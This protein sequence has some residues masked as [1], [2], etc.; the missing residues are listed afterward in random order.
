MNVNRIE[1][2]F[3]YNEGD[4]SFK[5]FIINGMFKETFKSRKVNSIYFDTSVFTAVS[6]NPKLRAR[7][8]LSSK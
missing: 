2:K 1:K 4:E 6:V 3:I 5:L 7:P 8:P